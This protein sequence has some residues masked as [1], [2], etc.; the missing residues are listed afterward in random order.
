[1]GWD[2]LATV[3][4]LVTGAGTLLVAVFLWNQLKV[5]HRD[6]ERDFVHA[7][8]GRQQDLTSVMFCDDG[9]AKVVWKAASD[10][11][12]LSPEEKNRIRFIYQM[13]YMH[14]WNGWRL[15]R[16]GDDVER[17]KVQWGQIL[18]YPGQRRFYEE[19]GRDFLMRDPSLLELAEGVY[20]ELESQAA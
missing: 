17:F 15:K 10:W 6:S 7:V 14:I 11:S 18:E 1:M 3:S 9:T 5:Q 2:E 8:E 4:Q 12:S 13:F 19:R 16:D 20:Q